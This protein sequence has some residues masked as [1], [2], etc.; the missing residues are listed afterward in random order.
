MIALLTHIARTRVRVHHHSARHRTHP[1]I[2]LWV[3]S[4]RA[5]YQL[6]VSLRVVSLALVIVMAIAKVIVRLLAAAVFL[7]PLLAR[8][9]ARYVVTVV[10]LIYIEVLVAVHAPW[11]RLRSL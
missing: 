3:A 10:V 11:F 5:V 8:I 4:C 1:S 9:L 6:I 2:A 7:A